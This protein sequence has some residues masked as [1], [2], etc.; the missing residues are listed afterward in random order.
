M[1]NTPLVIF[2]L[3]KSS[4][5]HDRI[6]TDSLPTTM[7]ASVHWANLSFHDQK[8]N[9]LFFQTLGYVPK[10]STTFIHAVTKCA[11]SYL[12]FFTYTQHSGN[13]NRK[14]QTNIIIITCPAILFILKLKLHTLLH[15]CHE[16]QSFSF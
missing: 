4:W 6:W 11:H 10:L 2:H 5:A 12:L 3:S 14:Y 9:H 15:C 16:R 1:L 7:Q 13:G 8:L